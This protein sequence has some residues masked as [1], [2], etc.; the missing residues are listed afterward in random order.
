ML[1]LLRHLRRF[2]AMIYVDVWIEQRAEHGASSGSDNPRDM[3]G[4]RIQPL[5]PIIW[6]MRGCQVSF[7]IPLV[8]RRESRVSN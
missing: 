7:S 5:L 8:G 6:G 1:V 4:M 3:R 2:S